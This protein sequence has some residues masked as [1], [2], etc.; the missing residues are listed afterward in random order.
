M[1]KT[2]RIAHV[3]SL[4]RRGFSDRKIVKHFFLL[5]HSLEEV[6][7]LFPLT[8]SN[9]VQE[10]YNNRQKSFEEKREEILNTP[11]P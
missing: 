2:L 11:L 10:E 7:S 9:M 8:E 1:E 5:G 6:L 4:R 3:V